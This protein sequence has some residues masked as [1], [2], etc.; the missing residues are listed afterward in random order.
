MGYVILT[1]YTVSILLLRDACCFLR[2]ET[3][4]LELTKLT[5]ASLFDLLPQIV[6][7]R[8]FDYPRL[9]LID[10]ST[11][12]ELSQTLLPGSLFLLRFACTFLIVL[13]L[14]TNGSSVVIQF[15][16]GCLLA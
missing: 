3:L 2:F 1:L 13:Y 4:T 10:G 11:A 12:F 16:C 8:G 7:V 15:L 6:V 14:L 9:W 5:I